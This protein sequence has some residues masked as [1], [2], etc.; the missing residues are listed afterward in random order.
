MSKFGMFGKITTLENKR[1]ELVGILL[2]AAEAMNAL[3]E[4][5]VYIVSVKE[6]EPNAIWVTEVWQD[7][8]AHKASLSIDAVKT[9]IQRGR[10]LILGMEIVESFVPQGGKG[11]V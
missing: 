3:E 5:E 7:E 9:L 4:C 6:E 11:L 8:H 10:P 2:E 1:D